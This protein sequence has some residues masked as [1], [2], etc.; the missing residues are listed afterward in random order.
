MFVHLEINVPPDGEGELDDKVKNPSDDDTIEDDLQVSIGFKRVI[1]K[2]VLPHEDEGKEEVIPAVLSVGVLLLR[3]PTNAIMS[4][5]PPR[6]L[7]S[8]VKVILG[9]LVAVG[10]PETPEEGILDDLPSRGSQWAG[11]VEG[12]LLYSVLGAATTSGPIVGQEGRPGADV[13][14]CL[15]LHCDGRFFTPC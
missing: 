11:C 7:G 5:P 9:F 15:G 12:T 2:A 10:G 14:W 4:L 6:R 13:L 8:K 3:A 1:T